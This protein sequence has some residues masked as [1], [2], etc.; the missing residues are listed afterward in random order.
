[1][2]DVCELFRDGSELLEAGDHHR[3]VIPLPRARELA[4]EPSSICGAL[5]GS[6]PRRRYQ[7]VADEFA[8]LRWTTRPLLPGPCLQLLG[9]HAEARG[10]L[11]V[12]AC[13]RPERHDY[14]V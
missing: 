10:P 11:A 7:E 3:A 14:R 13:L 8:A 9:R 5:A 12:A 6:V 2:D 4:S 1:M